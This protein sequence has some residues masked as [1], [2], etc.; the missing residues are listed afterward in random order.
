M[1][2]CAAL[3][4][5]GVAC[6]GQNRSGE[7]GLG[8]DV[9]SGCGPAASCETRARELPALTGQVMRALVAG[10]DFTCAVRDA[11][12]ALLCWGANHKGQ[13]GLGDTAARAQP[14]PVPNLQ[15][16]DIAAG[17]QHVCARVAPFDE[18]FCWGQNE[19]D[20]SGI[21]R[22]KVTPTP[23]RVSGSAEA[24]LVA[25]GSLHSCALVGN[26]VQCWGE[27]VQGQLG[28]G[29]MVATGDPSAV[30]W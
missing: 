24:S 10:G 5:G 21:G 27:N 29:Q 12:G 15:V 2:A 14:T 1:H 22:P 8:N 4:K 26:G 9:I 11:D 25:A 7:L 13:L 6:W 17:A 23:A 16:L 30:A 19:R 20:E 3:G 18:V 28:N